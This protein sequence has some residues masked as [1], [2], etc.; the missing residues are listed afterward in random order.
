MDKKMKSKNLKG[1]GQLGGLGVDGDNI[2]MNLNEIG[3]EVVDW[4]HLAQDRV[5]SELL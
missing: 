3:C 5:H 4:F 2:K 1:G